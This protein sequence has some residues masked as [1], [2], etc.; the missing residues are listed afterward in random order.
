[1]AAMPF[2]WAKIALIS[3]GRLL[4]FERDLK[5]DIPYP[6]MWDM[7]GGGRDGDETPLDCAIRETFEEL[8]VEVDPL[9]VVW[10]RYYPDDS[11]AAG[12][13]FYVAIME[14]GFGKVVFG[15]EGQQWGEMS[16]EEF[17]DHPMAIDLLKQRLRD[18][19]EEFPRAA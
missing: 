5:P 17:L 8:G 7:P 15:N 1:V 6:G 13:Y 4:V 12:N 18:Y 16:I 11:Q 3:G 9:T 19:L 10:E 2:A 14:A